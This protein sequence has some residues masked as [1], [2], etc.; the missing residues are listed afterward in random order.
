M[1]PPRY[2]QLVAG[3][4]LYQ[5]NTKRLDKFVIFFSLTSPKNLNITK[6]MISFLSLVKEKKYIEFM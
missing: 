2:R 3:G 4:K 6:A 5:F 1:I